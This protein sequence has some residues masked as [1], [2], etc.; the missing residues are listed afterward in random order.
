MISLPRRA[1]TGPGGAS[2]CAGPGADSAGLDRRPRAWPRPRLAQLA[3]LATL[4]AIVAL[5]VVLSTQVHSVM[6]PCLTSASAPSGASSS[7]SP[8]ASTPLSTPA[9][10]TAA[11]AVSLAGGRATGASGAAGA[12][13]FVPVRSLNCQAYATTNK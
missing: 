8:S 4:A 6:R 11:P 1:A 10:P 2:G 7:A 5:C 3:F 9:S 13:A 12:A